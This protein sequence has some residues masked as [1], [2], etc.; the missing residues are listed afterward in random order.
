MS[1]CWQ[2]AYF[3]CKKDDENSPCKNC[4]KHSN[5]KLW[6]LVDIE[7]SENNENENNENKIKKE[8]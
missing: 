4:N 8:N 5:F 1:N 6:F 3:K 7:K 2:C